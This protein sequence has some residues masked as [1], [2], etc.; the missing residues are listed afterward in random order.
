M[1]GRAGSIRAVRTSGVERVCAI[2]LAPP[3]S[4][5]RAGLVAFDAYDALARIADGDPLR[6]VALSSGVAR[7]AVIGRADK[8]WVRRGLRAAVP[9]ASA[10][11]S[12]VAAEIALH[13]AL[14]A[15]AK[16]VERVELEPGRASA[17]GAL[18][19]DRVDLAWTEEDPALVPAGVTS[20]VTFDARS[21]LPSP[22]GPIVIATRASTLATDGAVVVR[23]LASA[24]RA[25][26]LAD[27]ANV[28][29]HV[30]ARR[31]WSV[32][33][34]RVTIGTTLAEATRPTLDEAAIEWL[35]AY[36]ARARQL[37]FLA[38]PIDVARSCDARWLARAE[39]LA[40]R[41]E[42]PEQETSVEVET[43]LAI[44]L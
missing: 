27:D 15:R 4:I 1:S 28:W 13:V 39:R 37:G 9:A 43:E 17:L 41:D 32:E 40:L 8:A 20:W 23:A 11:A 24:V 26:L 7:S 2:E 22:R 29:S 35:A 36:A 3:A 16:E 42:L 38:R 25:S 44:A 31:G 18:A 5:A 33:H 34:A 6:V 12:R 21:G 14:G 10:R 30:S 19:R